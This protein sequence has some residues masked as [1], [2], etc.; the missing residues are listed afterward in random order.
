MIAGVG[1]APAF[2]QITHMTISTDKESYDTGETIMVTGQVKDRI[3]TQEVTLR[4]IA[5][6]G[7]I[8]AVKQLSVAEDSTFETELATGA[9]LWKY[10][11]TYEI[12]AIYGSANR[13]ADT[14]F[15]YAGDD[16][17]MTGPDRPGDDG[18]MVG[19]FP[20]Q[21]SITGGE[22]VSIA[23]DPD[24][25][26]LIIMI[27]STDDGELTISL[28]SDIIV[29]RDNGM[30]GDDTDFFVLV[31]DAEVDD[32][33]EEMSGD[34]RTLT[35]P[36]SA[37]SER[38]EIIGSWVIPEFGTIAVLVLAAAIISII[39]ISSRSRLSIMPKY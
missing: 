31:D 10:E 20:I 36:F 34:V 23:E 38:I 37:G 8:I 21:Y 33:T 25:N 11:G 32:Y 29:A 3:T 35:I 2:G 16:G 13:A 14:T 28:P 24:Q 4:V 30:E 5:P 27:E 22:V 17:S 39:A 6:N 12:K 7:N 15:E 26:S 19:G 18:F 9:G 1:F